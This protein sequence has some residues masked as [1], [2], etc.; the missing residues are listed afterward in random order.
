MGFLGSLFGV[1]DAED[2]IYAGA[3]RNRAEGRG[4]YRAASR[5]Q[6]PYYQTGTQG[7]NSL[8]NYLGLNGMG[9]QQR[10]Y[11]RYVQGPDVQFRMKEGIDAIDNSYAARSGGTDSG[12]LRKAQINYGTGVATQD[13]SNFLSRL[14]GVAGMGQNSANALT[15]ARYGTANIVTGANSDQA[16]GIANANLAEGNIL[17]NLLGGGMKLLGTGWNPFSGG[18]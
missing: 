7:L 6:R 17:G 18:K 9:A 13:L 8:A 4:A 5:L 15:N 16:S 14:S 12:A 11:D 10:A 1:D 2:A 3:R